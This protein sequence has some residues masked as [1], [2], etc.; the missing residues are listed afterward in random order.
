MWNI[1][2]RILSNFYVWAFLLFALWITFLDTN[3][4][5]V[6]YKR[7]HRL[8]ELEQEKAYYEKSIKEIEKSRKELINNPNLLEKFAREKYFMRKKDEEVYVITPPKKP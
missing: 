8:K 7:Y 3:S 2:Q 5:I 4:L 1:T 6:Q